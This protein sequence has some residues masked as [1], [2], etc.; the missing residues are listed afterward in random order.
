MTTKALLPAAVAAVLVCAGCGVR[1]TSTPAAV[2]AP[3][4]HRTAPVAP[5]SPHPAPAPQAAPAAPAPGEPAGGV[6][7]PGT[8][9]GLPTAS[10]PASAAATSPTTAS[11][12]APAAAPPV[13]ASAYVFSPQQAV[14]AT[15]PAPS[16]PGGAPI[17]P[18]SPAKP[19]PVAGTDTAAAPADTTPHARGELQ[20]QIVPSATEIATGATVTMD[21]M[22]SSDTAVV[23]APLHVSFDPKVMAFVDS[24]PGD[25]LA[26][27][28]SSVVFLADGVN[29]PGDVAVAAGRVERIQGATGTGLLCRIRLR[30]V[31]P[32][33]T[34]VI[35]GQAKAWGTSGEELTVLTEGTT[36]VVR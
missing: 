12:A 31:G 10:V 20:L 27:G 3:A 36:T 34:P 5:A 9:A 18:S 6:P 11:K 16:K 15:A 23:D 22:A 29:R 28:G 1:T 19:A 25:F 2:T 7:G 26:Q 13:T 35:V 8:S 33:S 17:P 24:A 32:G 4:V 14:S 30:G 21:V